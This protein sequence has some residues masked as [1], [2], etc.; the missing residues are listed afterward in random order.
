[1]E[2]WQIYYEEFQRRGGPAA[3]QKFSRQEALTEAAH[4]AYQA[5]SNRLTRDHGWDDERTLVVMR[6]LNG[7]VSRWVETGSDDWDTLRT[8]LQRSE[9]ELRDGFGDK[10]D[11][12]P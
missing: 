1:M 6:G 3:G 4:D 11:S 8:E 12:P 5:A 10:A 7:T 9:D 2:A